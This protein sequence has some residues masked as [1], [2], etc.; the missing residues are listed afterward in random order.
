MSEWISAKNRLPEKGGKY[1][2]CWKG[3]LLPDVDLLYY[4]TDC[5]QF[6]FWSDEEGDFV[7]NIEPVKEVTHWMP[8]PELPEVEN[9]AD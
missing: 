7:W 5:K 6:G 9:E 3:F 2:V 1:L 8:I 4:S